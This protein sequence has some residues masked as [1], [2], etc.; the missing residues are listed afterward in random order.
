[1]FNIYDYAINML[2]YKSKSNNHIWECLVSS[3][4]WVNFGLSPKNCKYTFTGKLNH[5]E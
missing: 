3:M 4:V 2:R 1:M 5:I